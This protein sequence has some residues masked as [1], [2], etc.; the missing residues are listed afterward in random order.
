MQCLS[1]FS[2]KVAAADDAGVVERMA[3]LLIRCILDAEPGY[4]VKLQILVGFVDM[5]EP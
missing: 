5:D 4:Q 2:E 1:T 3:P